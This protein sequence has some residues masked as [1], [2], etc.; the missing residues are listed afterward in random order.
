LQGHYFRSN[1]NPSGYNEW[2][3]ALVE[4]SKKEELLEFIEKQVKEEL[5]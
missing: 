1:K 2:L 3:P 4:L 5:R